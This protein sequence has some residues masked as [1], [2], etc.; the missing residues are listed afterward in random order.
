MK[1]VT[2]KVRE[3]TYNEKKEC[4]I[5]AIT[6]MAWKGMSQKPWNSASFLQ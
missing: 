6:E 3:L 2:R 4:L 1:I 5:Y